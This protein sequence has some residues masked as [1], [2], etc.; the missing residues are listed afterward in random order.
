MSEST[1]KYRSAFHAWFYDRFN[2]RKEDGAQY[3]FQCAA[4]G[5]S[6]NLVWDFLERTRDKTYNADTF[7]K[8]A[9][10]ILNEATEELVPMEESV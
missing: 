4:H 9:D 2:D 6:D 10:L 7:S 8:A 3:L 5:D 1:A